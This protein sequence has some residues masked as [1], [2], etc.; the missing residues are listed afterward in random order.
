MS[1]VEENN[2]TLARSF[3]EAQANADLHALD[4]MLATDFVNHNKLPS[5]QESDRES[6]KRAISAYHAAL[7][8]SHMIIED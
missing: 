2:R 5:G 3:V 4:E 1:E 7:S 8:E 6:Y